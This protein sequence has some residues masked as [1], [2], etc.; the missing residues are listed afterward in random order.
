MSVS[1]A[2]WFF[3]LCALAAHPATAAPPIVTLTAQPAAFIT[4]T[5]RLGV[6]L[7]GATTW[8]ADQLSANVL[9]NPGF[10]PLQDRTLIIVRDIAGDSITDDTPWLARESGF[11]AGGE[12]QVRSGHATGRTGRVTQS[13]KRARDAPDTFTLAP[14]PPGLRAG[15]AIVLTTTA[16]APG[17][18]M[19]W[20][21]AGE[22]SSVPRTR[23]GS[24][25]CRA[26]QLI[27]R[28]T[29]AARLDHHLDAIGA[30]AGKL[31][32]INGPWRLSFWARGNGAT[33]RVKF[34]RH[35]S[36]AFIDRTLTA[37]PQWQRHELNFTAQ[38]TGPPGTLSLSFEVPLGE[39]LLDD[40]SLAPAISGPGGFRPEVVSLLRQLQPGYLRDWQG[41][42]G[43]S[44]AN[45]VRPAFARQPARNRPGQAEQMYFYSLPE[46]LELCAAVGATPW[47]VG[48]PL[49]PDADWFE[50]GR[51]LAQAAARHGFAEVLVEFGNE[52]WNTLFR[53][54]GFTDEATHLAVADRAFAALQE[55]A[56]AFGGIV[57]VI[58]AQFANPDSAARLASRAPRASRIAVAPYFLYTLP[59]TS[60]ADAV[61]AAFADNSLALKTTA[62]R[63][64]ARGKQ[65]AAY[66]LN[67]H[68]TE[69]DAPLEL[70]NLAVGGAHSAAALARR[71]LQG[72]LAGMRE[73]AVYSLAGFDSYTAQR[74]L[75]RL[76]GITRDIAPGQFRP[77]GLALVLL[78]RAYGGA[79]HAS[80][81]DGPRA[82]CDALTAV[83][84][85]HARGPRVAIASAA[86]TPITVRTHLSCD[87]PITVELID[88]TDSSANNET[89][90]PRVAIQRTAATCREHWQFDLPARSV[91]VLR[92][93]P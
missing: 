84:F 32:P 92:E 58:G 71:L 61:A 27:G 53:P 87:K 88:G 62:Q 35:G 11:W 5:P 6:N 47:V 25:G 72:T 68:T 89:T 69:G 52:N 78:N 46:F 82:A 86:N 36:P 30:R 56:G 83:W 70:R 23:P 38:D 21:S 34:Q 85:H 33:L 73:Q 50:M 49:M 14:F 75:V 66:E 2:G 43:D 54:G 1:R 59:N 29:Q 37:S 81:C 79:A 57:P 8:G 9:K 51:F 77:T 80:Q 55:G 91:A 19:W 12:F 60:T 31:L 90:P 63:V 26:A 24:P 42:L 4:H 65:L 93:K 67:F 10:E 22:V 16:Q 48:P 41:Q 7:G 13:G 17:V 39:V 3:L 44:F 40:V 20:I 28:D 76:W 64:A 18:P 45:R 74:Q 15:D